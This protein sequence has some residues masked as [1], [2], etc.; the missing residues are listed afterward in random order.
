MNWFL[1]APS[2]STDDAL[3]NSLIFMF[4]MFQIMKCIILHYLLFVRH[5]INKIKKKL[6]T[7]PDIAAFNEMFLT[8]T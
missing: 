3:S 7:N 2:T 8:V 6:K 4:I 1:K 5:R